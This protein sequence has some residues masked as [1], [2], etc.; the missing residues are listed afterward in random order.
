MSRK[1]G[2]LP[3]MLA[4]LGRGPGSPDPHVVEEMWRGGDRV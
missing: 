3:M 1:K 4:M 2:V